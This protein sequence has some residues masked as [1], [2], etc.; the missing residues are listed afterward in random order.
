MPLLFIVEF[1]PLLRLAYIN[2]QICS[3]PNTEN[4]LTKTV[5]KVVNNN[6]TYKKSPCKIASQVKVVK[7]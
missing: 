6:Q 3:Y 5:D 2:A 4:L 1:P 7:I